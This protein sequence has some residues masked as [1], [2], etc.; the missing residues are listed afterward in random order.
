[1]FLTDEPL[2]RISVFV[3]NTKETPFLCTYFMGPTVSDELV[4]LFCDQPILGRY[5]KLI[6]DFETENA[7][8]PVRVF[9]IC[10][11]EVYARLTNG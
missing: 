2:G 7:T 9:K 8:G 6:L 3:G 4:N 1:M 5:V 10:E 11:V